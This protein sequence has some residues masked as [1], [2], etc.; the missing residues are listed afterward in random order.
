LNNFKFLVEIPQNYGT[1]ITGYTFIY[2]VDDPNKEFK[3][4]DEYTSY[5]VA[6]LVYKN[7]NKTEKIGRVA[8]DLRE[9]DD[10]K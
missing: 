10:K 6:I 4:P 1:Y 7:L 3:V 8:L 2:G 5:E 9:Y